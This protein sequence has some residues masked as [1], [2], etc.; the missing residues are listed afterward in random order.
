MQQCVFLHILLFFVGNWQQEIEP[1]RGQSIVAQVQDQLC[2][3]VAK[4]SLVAGLKYR[5]TLESQNVSKSCMW[6]GR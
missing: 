4:C 6:T 1:D 5:D 3:Q 2:G